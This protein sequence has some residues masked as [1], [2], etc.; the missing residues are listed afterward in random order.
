[1]TTEHENDW[2]EICRRPATEG[3]FCAKHFEEDWQRL[4]MERMERDRI[5]AMRQMEA[6]RKFNVCNN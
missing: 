1:M 5:N 2:C 3:R 6:G 4:K